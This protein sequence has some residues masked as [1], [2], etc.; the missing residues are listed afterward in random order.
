MIAAYA[1]AYRVIGDTAYLE[2]AVQAWSHLRTRQSNPDGELFRTYR[3]GTAKGDA[4]QED[5]AFV[6]RGML[7]LHDA[8]GELQYLREAI[9]LQGV[10]DRLY[11]DAVDGSYYFAPGSNELIV[12]QRSIHDSAIPSGNAEA[13]HSLLDLHERTGDSEYLRKA[14]RILKRFSGQAAENPAAHHR[15]VLGIHRFPETRDDTGDRKSANVVRARSTIEEGEE[16]G[17]Y[18]LR[19]LLDIQEGWHINANP[20]SDSLLIATNVIPVTD[21]TRILNVR[22]PDASPLV[23]AFSDP[24]VDVYQGSTEITVHATIP[25]GRAVRNVFALRVQACDER[26]CLLPSEIDLR[27]TWRYQP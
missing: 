2:R 9:R 1:E 20:A 22:Y 13:V 14:E 12:R 7:K 8:T 18:R 3:G 16:A 5:Y 17:A 11:W 25:G 21:D 26:R 6:L 15:L 10:M 19:V 27:P 24:P 23:T 4:Y